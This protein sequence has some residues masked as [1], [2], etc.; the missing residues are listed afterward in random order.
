MHSPNWSG[1]H[2]L[3]LD[4]DIADAVRIGMGKSGRHSA[5]DVRWYR[6]DSS[7]SSRRLGCG[8]PEGEPD[9]DVCSL[10]T[11]E[12]GWQK[13]GLVEKILVSS[14][15]RMLGKREISRNIG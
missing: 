10:P 7:Y 2:G 13:R 9:G 6:E 15:G 11:E 5:A 14:S 4:V 1:E 8:S 12:M 3:F